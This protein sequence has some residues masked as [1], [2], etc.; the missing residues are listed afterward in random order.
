MI[1]IITV[2]PDKM[3][4]KEDVKKQIYIMFKC[5]RNRVQLNEKCLQISGKIRNNLC[6]DNKKMKNPP[7]NY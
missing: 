4:L 5:E 1:I 3:N 6:T 2:D 7:K